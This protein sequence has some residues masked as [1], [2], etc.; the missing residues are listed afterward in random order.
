MVAQKVM[1]S[2]W[3]N[4][5]VN[6]I[7]IALLSWSIWVTQNLFGMVAF[8]ERGDRFTNVDGLAMQAKLMEKLHL[9]ENR[10]DDRIDRLPPEEWRR[11]IMTSLSESRRVEKLVLDLEKS[12]VA[13]FV[14]KEE[15]AIHCLRALDNLKLRSGNAQ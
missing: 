10:L 11:H 2:P 3:V 13:D 12:I 9:A 4:F 15:V 1:S 7:V 8:M 14:P 5:L 6:L